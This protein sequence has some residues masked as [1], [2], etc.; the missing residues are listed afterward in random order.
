MGASRWAAGP[1][2]PAPPHVR[3]QAE[4]GLVEED[5]A[6]S[7]PLGVCLMAGQHSVTQ[8]SMAAWSRSAARRWG[9]WTVQPRRW[10]SSAHT[11]AGW[12][13]TPVSRSMTSAMRSSVH[14]SPTNPLAVAP[15]SRGLFHGG[16]LGVRKLGCRAARPAAAQRLGAALLPA[17]V[18]DAHGLG[19]DLELAGDLGLVD[20]GG[21]QLGRP[22][23]AGLEP[24]TFLL[25]R[26]AARDGWHAPDPHLAGSPAPTRP[27]SSTRHPR[28]FYRVLGVGLRAEHGLDLPAAVATATASGLPAGAATATPPPA[29]WSGRPRPAAPLSAHSGRPGRA[30]GRRTPPRCER[31]HSGG[32]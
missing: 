24:V 21:E 22:Q 7:A 29:A 4:R 27:C 30:G 25:G 26:R 31:R 32:G 20:A 14:S 9:R 23:P 8:R 10:C 11:Q 1:G 12:C 6:G 18:P 13:W 16:E 2:A 28:P 19:R 5:Q 15:S 17:G 3:G